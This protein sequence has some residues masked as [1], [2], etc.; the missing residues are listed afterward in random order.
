MAISAELIGS[1][2]VMGLAGSLHCVGMCGPLTLSLPVLH[3]D[4]ISRI[5]GG[6]I[7]NSGR[8]L[9][10]TVMG[11]LLGS[12][13]HF[14]I[15]TKWQSSLSI[16]LGVIVLLYLFLPKKYSHF[17]TATTLTKP[18]RLLRQQLGR[19]FQSRKLSSLFY[20]GI[21]NGFLPCGLVFLALTSSLV[22][23]SVGNG[24]MFMLFFGIGTFPL[25]FATALMGNYINQVIRGKARQLVPVLL[26]LMAIALI[27]RGME[28][29]IPFISPGPN[30]QHHSPVAECH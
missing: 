14:I 18:F 29:G 6:L 16:A 24:A 28:L 23:A 13:G 2:F 17:A 12:F 9:S 30:D 20:I 7:Y 22:S 4:A 15:S 25:M 10:Y 26:F 21:W 8:I 1:A 27:L 5:S 19:L 11:I 3:Q